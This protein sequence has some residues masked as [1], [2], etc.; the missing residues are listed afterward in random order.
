MVRILQE[1]V[2][3]L[4]N[5]MELHSW[6]ELE[7]VLVN[8]EEKIPEDESTL[9]L[10][11]IRELKDEPF[12]ESDVELFSVLKRELGGSQQKVWINEI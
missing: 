5:D 8:K 7:S 11:T 3:M 2:S 9:L 1:N 4:W 6:E 12:P 10:E